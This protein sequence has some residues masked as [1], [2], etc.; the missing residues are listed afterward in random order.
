MVHSVRLDDPDEGLNMLK[1]FN[2]ANI[3]QSLIYLKNDQNIPTPLYGKAEDLFKL[4][5]GY[6]GEH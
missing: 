4:E 5:S 1:I 3:R 6:E 2:S